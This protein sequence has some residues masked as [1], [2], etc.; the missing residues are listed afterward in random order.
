MKYKPDQIQTHE[1]KDATLEK[2]KFSKKVVHVAAGAPDEDDDTGSGFEQ[3]TMWLDTTNGDMYICTDHS[4]EDASWANM[5]GDDINPPFT[6]QGS[7]YGY[8]CGHFMDPGSPNYPGNIDRYALSSSGDG[9]DVGE[10]GTAVRETV[11]G[12]IR[13]D[14]YGYCT[15]GSESP[16]NVSKDLIQ[17]FTLAAPTTVVDIGETTRGWS[18]AAGATNGDHG[19][20]YSG[21]EYGSPSTAVTTIDKFALA[22]P[23]V[24]ASDSG[25]EIT[26]ELERGTGTSD[27]ANAYGYLMGGVNADS[28]AAW[29]PSGGTLTTIER[30]SFA[31][32]GAASDYSEMTN[33][34]LMSVGTASITHGYVAGGAARPPYTDI[35]V[36]EKF[37]FSAP[38]TIDDVGDLT[39][40]RSGIQGA[41]GDTHAY[42]AGGADW[43]PSASVNIIDRSS[44]SADGNSADVGDLSE[45]GA[46]G[47]GFES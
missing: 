38:T 47:S 40:A 12:S 23:P 2:G 44:T 1:I 33:D 34:T 15:G 13:N 10:L 8:S 21:K 28:S 24:T 20:V 9:S 4:A 26:T 14:S 31:G 36:V 27:T 32:S 29:P 7:N 41:S 43:G 37:G 11:S 25:M 35:N 30:F 6:I 22:A 18:Y 3:G 46:S 16:P 5:E 42:H 19:F 45:I 39:S 17:R